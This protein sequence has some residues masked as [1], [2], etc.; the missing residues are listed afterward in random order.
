[1]NL[2][3]FALRAAVLKALADRVEAALKDAK[4]ALKGGMEGSGADRVSAALP[5]GT[6]VASLPLAGGGMKP[7]VTD[8]DAFALWVAR[9][10]PGEMVPA[11]RPS[12]VDAVLKRAADDGVAVDPATGEAIP[13]VAFVEATTYVSVN[14]AKGSAPGKGGRDAIRDAWQSGE[15]DVREMLSLPAGGDGDD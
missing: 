10:Y 6:K 9:N 4:A 5:D 15:L 14:F 12:Y 7:K 8:P 13:G 2:R 3:D 1:M 11:V